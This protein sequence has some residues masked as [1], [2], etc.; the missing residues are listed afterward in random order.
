VAFDA[1]L[2]AKERYPAPRCHPDTRAAAQ[3]VVK[4]WIRRKG[5]WAE[6]VIMWISGAPGVGKSAIVQ[7]VCEEL[8]GDDG[9]KQWFTMFGLSDR[10]AALFFERGVY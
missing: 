4:N 8:G 1:L 7:T 2:N 9:S 10:Y 6:K 3:I 5:D